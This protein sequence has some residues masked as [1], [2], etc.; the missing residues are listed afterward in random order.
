MNKNTK[1]QNIQKRF[2]FVPNLHRIKYLIDHAE[3][4]VN[5]YRE[6][7]KRLESELVGS[8][9]MY[10]YVPI[11]YNKK[12]E[13]ECN[14]IESIGNK[15]IYK[16][17]FTQLNKKLLDVEEDAFCEVYLDKDMLPD[18]YINY[19]K[20]E[21]WKLFEYF[22]IH[23]DYFYLNGSK[24]MHYSDTSKILNY[25]LY[26]YSFNC[27]VRKTYCLF[28]YEEYDMNFNDKNYMDRFKKF[29]SKQ[30][31]TEFAINADSLMKLSKDKQLNIIIR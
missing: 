20:I 10:V 28:Y 17:S 14:E 16:L 29:L 13:K 2:E 3:Y 22:V 18:W 4:I 11:N 12:L 15:K 30:E 7:D 25:P 27:R 31:E 19:G 23:N 21:M 26:K 1:K 5:M 9:D 24:H 6:N 8:L